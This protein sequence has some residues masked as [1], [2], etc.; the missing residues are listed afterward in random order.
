MAGIGG[1]NIHF[2]K[3]SCVILASM[4]GSLSPYSLAN[5]RPIPAAAKHI[6]ALE[7]RYSHSFVTG[8]ASVTQGLL[9]NGFQGF[10]PNGRS[11]NKAMMLSMVRAVPHQASAKIIAIDV[12]LY[13]GTAIASGLEADTD[14][15]SPVVS[16]RRWLDT[17]RRFRS[18][19]RMIASA[20]IATAP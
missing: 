19:W 15:G 8:D 11:W 13:G 10:G 6:I 5:A 7:R 17:W 2:A 14:I 4:A 9:T 3:L 18:G 20:E 16:Y 12:R 1:W